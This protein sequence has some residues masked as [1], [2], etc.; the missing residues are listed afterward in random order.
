MTPS[1]SANNKNLSLRPYTQKIVIVYICHKM[2]AKHISAHRQSYCLPKW[3]SSSKFNIIVFELWD[4]PAQNLLIRTFA[5]FRKCEHKAA[6]NFLRRLTSLVNEVASTCATT[7]AKHYLG[8]Q[9]D[10]CKQVN[11]LA[12]YATFLAPHSPRLF[13]FGSGP[14]AVL[15]LLNY[16]DLK[17]C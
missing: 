14:T 7:N 5:S 17:T 2:A 11:T 6:L 9:F 4:E 15:Y 8:S 12:W 3:S 10:S 16:C 13:L 1:P